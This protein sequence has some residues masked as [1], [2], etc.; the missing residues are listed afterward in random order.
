MVSIK[1]FFL[2]DFGEMFLS[3]GSI[4]FF[5]SSNHRLMECVR[6]N[7]VCKREKWLLF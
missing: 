2:F 3:L 5:S 1:T 6:V 4:I 7:F